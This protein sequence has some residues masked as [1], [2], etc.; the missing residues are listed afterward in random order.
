M[1]NIMTVDEMNANAFLI[2]TLYQHGP[3]SSL[4]EA[5]IN[6]PGIDVNI[7]D[8]VTLKTPI[9]IACEKELI[10][11]VKS[12][13]RAGA[14]LFESDEKGYTAISYAC[15]KKSIYLEELINYI[16]PT[17]IGFMN[18]RFKVGT[19]ETLNEIGRLLIDEETKLLRALLNFSNNDGLTPLMEAVLYEQFECVKH[20]LK[21]KCS[22]EETDEDGYNVFIY[23]C[24]KNSKYLELLIKHINPTVQKIQC[25]FHKRQY[26]NGNTMLMEA[27]Y[28][29]RIDCMKLIL[30]YGCNTVN[31]HNMHGNSALHIACYLGNTECVKL[32]LENQADINSPS[33]STKDTPLIHASYRGH[34]ECIAYLLHHNADIYKLNIR[35]ENVLDIAILKDH[36]VLVQLLQNTIINKKNTK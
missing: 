16:A 2:N 8:K 14:T 17:L 13:L 3:V 26:I 33:H 36:H 25:L 12:L 4:C 10:Q 28:Y 29:E 7:Q 34:I 24:R 18:G 21:Y 6:T 23:A 20:L 11:T 9:M 5:V 35:G 1:W 27:T 31:R 19:C 22:V 15:R 32:L 30:E